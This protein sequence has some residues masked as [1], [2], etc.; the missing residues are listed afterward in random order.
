[1]KNRWRD[2]D[3]A[4]FAAEHV[5]QWGEDLALRTYSTR[6]LGAEEELVLHGGGN[7]SVK[8]M[9]TNLLGE[10]IRAIFVKA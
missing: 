9:H 4:L 6:L 2:E 7:T 5:P 10:Q 3:A 1:M 8:G